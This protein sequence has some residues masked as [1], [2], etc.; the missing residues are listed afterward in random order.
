MANLR[1]YFDLLSKKLAIAKNGP[2]GYQLP[3]FRQEDVLELEISITR[4]IAFVISDFELVNL[5]GFALRASVGAVIGTSLSTVSSFTPD[6]SNTKLT[7]ALSLNVAGIS[8]LSDGATLYFEIIATDA[9]GTYGKRFTTTFE[10]AIY[11]SGSLVTP[12]DDVALGRAEASRLYLLKDSTSIPGET[13]LWVSAN[14][15][16]RTLQYL[17]DDGTMKYDVL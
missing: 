8:A 5:S 17:D 16:R 1:L 14:G 2:Y 15:T 9:V 3:P 7:G 6:E 13:K 11:T 4:Q 10:K 12:P